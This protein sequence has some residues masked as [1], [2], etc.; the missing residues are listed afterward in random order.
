MSNGTFIYTLDG[1][2]FIAGKEHPFSV[3]FNSNPTLFDLTPVR[4]FSPLSFE[5][6]NDVYCRFERSKRRGELPKITWRSGNQR[7]FIRSKINV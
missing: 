2:V 3:H 7:I 5:K 4:T 1:S 6:E